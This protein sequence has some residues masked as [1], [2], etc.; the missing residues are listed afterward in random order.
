MNRFIGEKGITPEET[1]TCFPN[2]IALKYIDLS[3]DERSFGTLENN[4]E[5]F[6]YILYSNVFNDFPEALPAKLEKE[7][8][9]V[10]AMKRVQVTM[11]LYQNPGWK[12]SDDTSGKSSAT[13]LHLFLR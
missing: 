8:I 9:T 6:R 11:I 5:E 1:G 13:F 10:K 4:P 7:W 12:A 3:D 2:N